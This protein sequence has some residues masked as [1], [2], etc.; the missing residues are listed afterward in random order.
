[1]LQLNNIVLFST[2]STIIFV[3]YLNKFG[4]D[5]FQRRLYLF[6]LSMSLIAAGFDFLGVMVERSSN[7]GALATAVV[8]TAYSMFMLCQNISNYILLAFIDYFA[9]GDRKR[10]KKMIAAIS[11]FL[12]LYALSIAANARFHFYFSLAPDNSYI[13]GELYILRIVLGYLV[14]PMLVAVI[15]LS[16]K[17][18]KKSQIYMLFFF[19]LLIT[20]GAMMDILLGGD[21]I[22]GCSGAAFLYIYFFIV[23]TDM[24]ID[25]LT[26][27]DNRYSFNEFIETLSKHNEKRTYSVVMIDMDHF[28]K[29]NDTFGHAEGDNALRDMASILKTTLRRSNFVARY[30]GDEFIIIVHAKSNIKRLMER[31]EEAVQRQN[32]SGLRP[33]KLQISYG[34]ADYT[35]DSGQSID[36][37]IAHVDALMYAN[38]MQH[39]LQDKDAKSDATM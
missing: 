15:L 37:F 14:I 10:A 16:R 2:I 30:G 25:A 31:I 35:A 38:K 7:N 6:I 8:Y 1:M 24:K 9:H 29:I 27:M 17:Y 4:T 34:Y 26:G 39:R 36:N 33:Y 22:W 28:K 3:Y 5:P 32:D 11:V 20:L 21:I 12:F 19:S 18:F 23:Q 13:R